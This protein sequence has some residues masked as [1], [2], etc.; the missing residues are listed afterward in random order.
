ML[1]GTYLSSHRELEALIRINKPDKGRRYPSVIWRWSYIIISR[2]R[3]HNNWGFQNILA[4]YIR[5]RNVYS[6]NGYSFLFSYNLSRVIIQE[7]DVPKFLTR[8]K[9]ENHQDQARCNRCFQVTIHCL[10]LNLQVQAKTVSGSGGAN[11]LTK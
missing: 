8:F 11:R 7:L 4:M 1:D 5:Q 3:L 10:L 6:G 2:K 9:M